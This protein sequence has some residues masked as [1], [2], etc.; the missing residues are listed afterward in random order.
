MYQRKF[1]WTDEEFTA[2]EEHARSQCEEHG[3]AK[4]FVVVEVA[5]FEHV[6]ASSSEPV[7]VSYV[8]DTEGLL[9]LREQF[10]EVVEFTGY[11]EDVDALLRAA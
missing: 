7:G 6:V 3:G 4:M 11:G 1:G 2:A 5:P 9:T 8:V 10:D